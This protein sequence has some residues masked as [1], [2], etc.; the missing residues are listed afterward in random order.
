[1]PLF[2][3]IS[4]C[5]LNLTNKKRTLKEL[6]LKKI[7]SLLLPYLSFAIINYFFLMAVAWKGN[8]LTLQL[9]IDHIVYIFKLCGR[10]T[11]WFLPCIFISEVSF[12]LIH[13]NISN[14]VIKI[15]IIIAIFIIPFF[16]KAQHDTLLRSCTAIG[17]ITAGNYLFNIIT[18][19]IY[20]FSKY[21]FNIC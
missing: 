16:I 21:T 4:G 2:F 7:P 1:M 14:F 15:S 10:S 20:I 6:A 3:I 12:K 13:E 17:F 11:I 19:C 9:S 8:Y 18:T 5:L